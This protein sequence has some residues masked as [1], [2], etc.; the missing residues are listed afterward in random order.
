M[1]YLCSTKNPN[2][3]F[4]T[5]S[6]KSIFTIA[7]LI[8]AFINC[9]AQVEKTIIKSFAAEGSHITV[10]LPGQV[11]VKHWDK[12]IV[13]ITLTVSTDNAGEEIL[14]KLI[15]FGRYE[16]SLSKLNGFCSISMPKICA[17]NVF[18]DGEHINEFFKFELQLPHG[19]EIKEKS[20]QASISQ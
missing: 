18:I 19:M 16:M 1:T 14:K 11:E 15:T 12:D 3:H 8:F 20:V 5:N 7:L 17:N 10:E 2:D 9:Q 13:R 4:K 6:M